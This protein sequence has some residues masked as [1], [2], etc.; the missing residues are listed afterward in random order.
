MVWSFGPDGKVDANA[1]ANAGFN[2]DNIVSWK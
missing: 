1:K 2:K